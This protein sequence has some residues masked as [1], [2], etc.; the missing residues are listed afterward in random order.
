MKPGG[1]LIAASKR[2]SAHTDESL[3]FLSFSF[4][5]G[6]NDVSTLMWDQ[7]QSTQVYIHSQPCLDCS[8]LLYGGKVAPLVLLHLSYPTLNCLIDP[9]KSHHRY[10]FRPVWRFSARTGNIIAILLGR[11]VSEAISDSVTATNHFMCLSGSGCKP[12]GGR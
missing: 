11:D 3:F 6:G 5:L 10:Y 2:G 7:S 4:F 12:Q 8:N 9:T 1:Q